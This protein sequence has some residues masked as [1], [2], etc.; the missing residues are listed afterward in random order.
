MNTMIVIMKTN[1]LNE[2]KVSINEN[3]D[4]LNENKDI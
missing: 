3:K 2:N 1:S 4:S